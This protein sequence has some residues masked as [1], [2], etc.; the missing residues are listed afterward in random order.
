MALS[1]AR[2]IGDDR[3]PGVRGVVGIDE[4]I[5]V[6]VLGTETE[7]YGRTEIALP[8]IEVIGGKCLESL[9]DGPEING[10]RVLR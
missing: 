5:A 3:Q 4:K 7:A 10:C 2:R 1:P 6:H 8:E 9:V